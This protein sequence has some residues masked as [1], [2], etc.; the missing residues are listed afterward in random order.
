M[1]PH[2]GFSFM[3]IPFSLIPYHALYGVNGGKKGK[4]FSFCDSTKLRFHGEL[5]SVD[6]FSS[7]LHPSPLLSRNNR[8]ENEE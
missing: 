1:D 6:A 5:S 4:M 7:F 8:E 2:L 3:F